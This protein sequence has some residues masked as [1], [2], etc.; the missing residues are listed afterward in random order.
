MTSK[1][2]RLDQVIAR[3]PD[4]ATISCGGFQLNR[5]PM[6][7]VRELICQGGRRLNV[8]FLPNALPLDWLVAAG[9]VEFADVTFSGFQY[10]YGSVIP[11][12][13][14]RACENSEVRW[15]ERDALYLVQR[16]RAAAM[17]LSMMPVPEGA[18]EAGDDDVRLIRDPFREGEVVVV[19]KPLQPDYVLIHAQVAD[20]KGNLWVEDPVTDVLLAKAGRRVLATAER[21]E[22]RLT[23]TN[24]PSFLV[25]AVAEVPS[26]AWPAACAG[27]YRHDAEA[28]SRYV[29]A[30]RQ[31]RFA[32]FL[33]EYDNAL[34][35]RALEVVA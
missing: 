21:I 3:I 11:P 6:A 35:R 12:N 23:R 4:R 20:E 7:M 34:N 22:P 28:I 17:G 27:C 14:K 1:I 10:E 13:W 26:G 16:L 33:D 5:P 31:D 32:E 18:L 19:V 15:R 8:V 24:I 9:M 2:K 29:R 30:S 25:E